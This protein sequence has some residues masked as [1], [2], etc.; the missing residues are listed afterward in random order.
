MI[1]KKISIALYLAEVVFT[2][3]IKFLRTDFNTLN[4]NLGESIFSHNKLF[5]SIPVI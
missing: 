4:N 3:K 1:Y 5:L 2:F